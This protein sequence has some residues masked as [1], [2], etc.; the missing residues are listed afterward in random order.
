MA[1][2]ADAAS[3][4]RIFEVIE[5]GCSEADI[6][7]AICDSSVDLTLLGPRKQDLLRL[8]LGSLESLGSRVFLQRTAS[9]IG[10]VPA[11]PGRFDR[12]SSLAVRRRVAI[13]G[14]AF[15]PITNAHLTGAAE[16]VHSCSADEVWLVPCGPRPDKPKL[17]TPAV[18]RY[19]MCQ[20]AVNTTFSQ[21]FPVKVV[22]VECFASE[23]FYTY[24]LLCRLRDE[25]PEVDLAFVI[26]TDWL[27]PGS[28]MCDWTSRNWDWKPGDP[29]E[30]KTIV[31]G[32]RMLQ[33]F[34]FLVI[35]RPG[36]SVEATPDDPSGLKKFGP[37]LSWLVMPEGTTFI[38]GNLSS[39]EI[40]KRGSSAVRDAVGGSSLHMVEGLLPR[41]V[42]AYIRRH[43]FY[44]LNDGGNPRAKGRV[45]IF[46]GA[47]DPVTNSHLTVAANIIHSGCADEVWLVPCGPRP[48]EPWHTTRPLD[49]LS[50]LKIAVNQTFSCNFPVYVSDAECFQEQPLFTYD[51]LCKLKEMHPEASFSFVIGSDW[52]QPQTDMSSW[53]SRNWAWKPGD[54]EDQ[55]T[56]V[57]GDRMLAEFD[58]LVIPRP[59]FSV[60][61]TPEDPSGLKRFGPRLG[62]LTM[63]EDTTFIHGNVSSSEI[64][65][66]TAMDAKVRDLGLSAVD[67]LTPSGVLAYICRQ[68]LYLK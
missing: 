8:L 51:L 57:T 32:H 17:K 35:K 56:I 41:S 53:R 25:H 30:K 36:Y 20:V 47:F 9:L 31:T 34:S 50:M 68:D 23:A 48:D 37:R 39:T 49:R 38:Q 12:I 19:C 67:G 13:Y 3:V 11:P 21:R 15:D 63:P 10:G 24:D 6:C 40:R 1:S 64:R 29:E 16:V 28:N 55:Q 65:K 60:E 18:D 59:G 26:G 5:G 61:K 2:G 62:W 14:G 4:A 7:R 52:L 42:L 45:A 58:F 22:D 33:E 66:R 27:Q 54:P 43:G 46:G 44:N